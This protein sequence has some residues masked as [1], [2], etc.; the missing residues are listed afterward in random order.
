MS[1][2]K[3][4][5]QIQGTTTEGLIVVSGVY[6]YVETHGVPLDVVFSSLQE[7]KM[8]PCWMSFYKEALAAGMEHGRVLSKLEDPLS[9]VYGPAVRDSVIRGLERT[10]NDQR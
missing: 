3:T 8:V 1:K 6:R 9:D 2:K 10:F 4:S 7:R 5:L